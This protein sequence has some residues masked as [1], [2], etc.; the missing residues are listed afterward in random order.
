VPANAVPALIKK[1][2]HSRFDSFSKAQHFLPHVLPFGQP[3]LLEVHSIGKTPF[4]A[5]SIGR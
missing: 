3:T 5:K 4:K 2:K 1:I